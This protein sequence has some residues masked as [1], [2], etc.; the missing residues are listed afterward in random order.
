M[1]CAA[2]DDDGTGSESTVTVYDAFQ[3]DDYDITVVGAEVSSDLLDW[4]GTNGYEVPGGAG[5]VIDDYI[6][7]GFDFVAVRF[8]GARPEG[9]GGGTD[10]GTVPEDR[11]KPLAI[12]FPGQVTTFPLLI[13]SL[14]TKREVE[15][16][17]YTIADRRFEVVNYPEVDIRITESF[18]RHES[19]FTEWYQERLRAILHATGRAAFGVEYADVVN[20]GLLGYIDES[21]ATRNLIVTR[22]HGFV[23]PEAMTRDI[24]LRPATGH[25]AGERLRVR[26]VYGGKVETAVMLV[27]WDLVL[28]LVLGMGALRAARRRA[29]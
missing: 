14:S 8:E 6:G 13:S 9:G 12:R 25:K 10:G 5:E 11:A 7:R 26:V 28:I 1:G 19:V 23:D 29:S 22:F 24:E 18:E 16:L 21:L 20:A 17:L 27:P 2:G 15:I 3:V 4:L